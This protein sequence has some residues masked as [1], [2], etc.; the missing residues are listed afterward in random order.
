M[1]RVGGLEKED[2]TGH[3]NYT[4]ENHQLMGDLR[5]AKIERVAADYPPTTVRGD[6]DADLCVVGWGSTWA[7]IHSAVE[8]QRREGTRVAWIHLEHLNPLPNDLGDLLHRYE[9]VIVPELNH[10]QLCDV[11]RSRYLVDA[12]SVSKVAGLPFRTSEIEEAIQ[13]ASS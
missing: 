9:R 10:G 1:H 8:R 11:L 7:A 2:R 6:V 12:R 3:V 5:R 4:S 13:E